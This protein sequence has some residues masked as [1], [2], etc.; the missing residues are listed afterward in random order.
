MSSF[1][2]AVVGTAV[3]A[4]VALGASVGATVAVGFGV[5][6]AVGLGVLVAV[7]A[8]VGVFVGALVATATVG[9]GVIVVDAGSFS[10]SPHAATATT[11][12]TKRADKTTSIILLFILFFIS[13]FCLLSMAYAEIVPFIKLLCNSTIP[14]NNDIFKNSIKFYLNNVSKKRQIYYFCE[15]YN[16][17]LFAQRS[18]L[19]V[20]VRQSPV[21]TAFQI[22]Y[23]L[24]I[25]AHSLSVSIGDL[26]NIHSVACCGFHDNV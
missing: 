19:A 15:A 20:P 23:I 17:C 21:Y 22:I 1:A 14:Y 7:G 25:F 4:A 12:I 13:L 11:F 6:V 2:G 18:Y 26:C 16:L 3:G 10:S 5:A 9:V 24:R 8:T